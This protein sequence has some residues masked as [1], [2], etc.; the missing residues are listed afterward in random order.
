MSKVIQDENLKSICIELNPK[1]DEHAEV[2]QV[3]EKYF[4]K[5]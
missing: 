2:F 3:L 4:K 5:K 1:F